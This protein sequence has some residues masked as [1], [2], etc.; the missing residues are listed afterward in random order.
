MKLHIK[1]GDKVIVLAGDAKGQQGEVQ[2]VDL[3]KQRAVVQGV[4]FVSKHIKARAN[5]K[6]PDGGIIKKEGPIHVSNLKLIDPKS[7]KP[8]KAGFQTDV[9]TGNKTRIFKI[10]ATSEGSKK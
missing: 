3:K 2:S 10:K 1:K 8:A 7:G 4:N 6:Y 5:A 9:K